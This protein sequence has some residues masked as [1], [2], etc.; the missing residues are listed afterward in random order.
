MDKITYLEVPKLHQP[1]LI[2]GFEGWANAAEVSSHS[3]QCLVNH[4]NARHFASLPIENFYQLSSLRPTAVIKE[5][6]VLEVKFPANRFYYAKKT[7]SSDLILFQGTEPHFQWSKFVDLLLGLAERFDVS[8]VFTIG[9]TYDYLP[10]T[11]PPVV[12]VLFN[13]DDL[14]EKVTRPGLQLTE[15]SGPISI[16]TCVLEEAGKRGIKG[17]SLWGHAP[18]YLQA[19]NVQV[20]YAVLQQLIALTE[21]KM[22]LSDL[23][24]ASEYFG[25]QIDHLVE[26]DPKLKEVI[27]K[28]EDIYR[29]SSPSPS[30]AK[31]IDESKE[32][33]VIYIRAF[34]KR[35]EDGEK[36]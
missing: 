20:V 24:R 29:Q 2:I 13:H 25:Q 14:K 9:G 6:K 36:K 21:I 11:Y 34:L 31:K 26:Q 28:L 3:V 19:K 30:P 18:Q 16:H 23:E 10:H 8:Q 32:E 35:Q 7:G 15:Y 5:G 17:V 12:S 1:H 4:F 33:K 22:D 27:N